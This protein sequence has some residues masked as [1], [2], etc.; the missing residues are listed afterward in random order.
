VRLDALCVYSPKRPFE[1]HPPSTG[2]R[3]KSRT[4]LARCA[5]SYRSSPTQNRSRTFA[6]SSKNRGRNARG[7]GFGLGYFFFRAS[8]ASEQRVGTLKYS[9]R[10]DDSLGNNSFKSVTR[11]EY[12]RI[13][14]RISTKYVGIER[15][16]RPRSVRKSFDFYVGTWKNFQVE[17]FFRVISIKSVTRYGYFC[18]NRRISTNYVGIKRLYRPK[19]V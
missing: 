9:R 1:V 11:C 19:C 8:G 5:R 7:I 13:N 16:F 14:R 4:L 2:T 6:D 10:F 12:Y 17:Q 3:W 15:L 18:I